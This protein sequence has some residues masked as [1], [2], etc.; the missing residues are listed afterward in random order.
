MGGA[1]LNFAPGMVAAVGF[2][3]LWGV[4]VGLDAADDPQPATMRT[5]AMA[6]RLRTFMISTMRPARPST[7]SEGS[8]A[9]CTRLCRCAFHERWSLS[10]ERQA[11]YA[12]GA[13][14][15]VSNV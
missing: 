10:C 5:S 9:Q 12:K 3:V 8:G 2:A 14:R 11:R 13:T 4:E 7:K 15:T 6:N 1:D